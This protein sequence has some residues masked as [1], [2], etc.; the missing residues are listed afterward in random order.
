MVMYRWV[1]ECG[2]IEVAIFHSV[3]WIEMA[4]S[5]AR[6]YWTLSWVQFRGSR[7]RTGRTREG[8]HFILRVRRY[9]SLSLLDWRLRR[10]SIGNSRQY[11][12]EQTKSRI[13]EAW[14][15]STRRCYETSRIRF[16]LLLLAVTSWTSPFE[17]LHCEYGSEESTGPRC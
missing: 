2:E 5:W 9:L 17:G 12:L 13:E 4:R 1:G 7:S 10:R 6:A 15:V 3:P 16:H 11:Q 8:W 14:K